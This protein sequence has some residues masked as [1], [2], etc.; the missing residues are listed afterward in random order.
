[1]ATKKTKKKFVYRSSITGKIITKAYALRNPA[2]T[3][4]DTMP[5]A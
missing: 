3:Y 5:K 1:M 4:K 2:T